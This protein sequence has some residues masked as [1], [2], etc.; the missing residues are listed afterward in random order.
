MLTCVY[1]SYRSLKPF[2]LPFP[3]IYLFLLT[4]F[5]AS[6]WGRVNRLGRSY[7][8]Q[9]DR[10]IRDLTPLPPPLKCS[11]DPSRFPDFPDSTSPGPVSTPIG[12]SGPHTANK[13]GGDLYRYDSETGKEG[14][15][16]LTVSDFF[17]TYSRF[18]GRN[19]HFTVCRN[20]WR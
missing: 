19:T 17:C 18:Y 5:R 10:K 11:G 6:S 2:P 8:T 15:M 14:H 12:R 20:T 1:M 7:V 16:G 13:N 4:V 3:V 9:W